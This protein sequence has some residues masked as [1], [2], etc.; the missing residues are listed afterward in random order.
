MKRKMRKFDEGGMTDDTESMPGMTR[1]TG[2]K[3]GMSMSSRRASDEDEPMTFKEAFA[4]ARANKQATFTFKN[5]KTGKMESFNTRTKD[6]ESK[7]AAS[8]STSKKELD[9]VK[10][11]YKFKEPTKYEPRARYFTPKSKL[12]E[13]YRPRV[14]SGRY[15]DPTS[16]YA[17]RVFS[18]LKKL[19]DVFGLRKEESVMRNMGVSREEARRRLKAKEE[20]GMRHGGSVK[21]MAGGGVA[22]SSAS[23]RA[24]GIA[25]KGKTRGRIV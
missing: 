24:D 17:E 12:P 10:L 22:R 5:P 4:K 9:E 2:G 7:P 15:D 3:S 23:K 6:E 19:G 11:P 14:G 8:S 20:S 25:K 21:R 1:Y 13:K 18:P 16:S